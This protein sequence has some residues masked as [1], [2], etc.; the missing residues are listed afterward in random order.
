MNG[1]LLGEMFLENS[2][3]MDLLTRCKPDGS[4]WLDSTPVFRRSMRSSWQL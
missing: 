2:E 3:F 1:I 4:N